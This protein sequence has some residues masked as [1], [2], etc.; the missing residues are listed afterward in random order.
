VLGNLFAEDAF[1]AGG[2]YIAFLRRQPGGRALRALA[3]PICR[4][5]GPSTLPIQTR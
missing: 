5:K 1:G 4:R 2:R 3:I